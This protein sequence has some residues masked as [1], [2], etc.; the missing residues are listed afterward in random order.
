[1]F[2]RVSERSKRSFLNRI[3]RQALTTN[4][5]RN[6]QQE[7]ATLDEQSLEFVWFLG[8]VLLH[9]RGLLNKDEN[10]RGV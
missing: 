3:L 10:T 9:E 6:T 8:R 2:G 7:L 4:L 5:A 1:M